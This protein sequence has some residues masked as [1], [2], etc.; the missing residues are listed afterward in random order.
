M[1]Y[2]I[3][4]RLDPI[5]APSD[6]QQ[7]FKD[8]LSSFDT[9]LDDSEYREIEARADG[10]MPAYDEA[11]AR[12]DVRED[13]NTIL[14]A[15]T[16]DHFPAVEWFVVHVRRDDREADKSEYQDNPDYYDPEPTDGVRAPVSIERDGMFDLAY[17]DIHVVVNNSDVTVPAGSVS[18]NEPT[19]VQ[20]ET[21]Y[22]TAEGEVSFESGIRLAD[23]QCHPGKIVAVETTEFSLRDSDW[24]THSTRGSPPSY[25]ADP[26]ES[27][28]ERTGETEIV[29]ERISAD[30]EQQILDAR[31][32]GDVQAQI[33]Q[34]LDILNVIDQ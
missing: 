13:I 22:A 8:W 18:I 34:I 12:F 28:P 14:T 32:A 27:F 16:E 9:V 19:G 4:T 15:L 10:T 2:V 25:L 3:R 29:R 21:L 11:V 20:Q 26:D 6:K 23:V 33:D 24:T 17:E 5:D 7:R 31:D 1:S 30:T